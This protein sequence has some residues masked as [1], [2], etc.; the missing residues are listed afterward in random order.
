MSFLSRLFGGGSPSIQPADYKTR[1]M[2][3]KLPHT[4]IDVRTAD[5]F[6]GGHIPGSINIAVN[7]LNAKLNKIPKDKPVIVY[8]QS[9]SRSSQAARTLLAAGYT[10]V[11]DMGGIGGWQRQGLPVKR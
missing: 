2:D 6:K 9:G 8:C 10:E 4:L 7:D 11:Y 3:P 1:Y 5:E